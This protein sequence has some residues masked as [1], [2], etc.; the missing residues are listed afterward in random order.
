M[1]KPEQDKAIAEYIIELKRWQG[2]G[3]DIEGQHSIADKILCE[4]IILL[5]YPEIVEEY[6]K[7]DKWYA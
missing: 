6:K 2:S 1:N 3:G 5:G 7:I 4:I